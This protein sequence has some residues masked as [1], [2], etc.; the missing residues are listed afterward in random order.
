ME[1]K[2][3]HF[4]VA[5][6]CLNGEKC[7]FQHPDT[8]PTHLSPEHKVKSISRSQPGGSIPKTKIPCR[9]YLQG[10]CTKGDFCTFEHSN[11]ATATATAF[12]PISRDSRSSIPCI[13]FQK[14]VCKTGKLCPYSHDIQS[15]R[16]IS[17]TL[18]DHRPITDI[19]LAASTWASSNPSF[20]EHDETK[21]PRNIG[22]ATVVFADG[23]S[24]STISLISNFSAVSTSDLSQHTSV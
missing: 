21:L 4:F 16:V 14:S 11:T 7:R 18:S 24:V 15:N 1:N 20:R 10:T 19:G 12:L 5:G 6:R 17:K 22:G 23:A 8:L 2:I 13:Y 3:C 9:F